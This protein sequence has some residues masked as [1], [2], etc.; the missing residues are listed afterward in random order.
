MSTSTSTQIPNQKASNNRKRKEKKND[1]SREQHRKQAKIR[2]GI[3]LNGLGA[4]SPIMLLSKQNEA[5][6]NRLKD[7]NTFQAIALCFACYFNAT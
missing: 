7:A 5:E 6:S 4:S 2:Q 1:I 3:Y